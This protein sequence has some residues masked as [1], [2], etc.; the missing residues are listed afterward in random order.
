MPQTGVEYTS[1]LLVEIKALKCKP[2]A[3]Y[4]SVVRMKQTCIVARV[5]YN[6]EGGR[7]SYSSIVPGTAVVRKAR[8][9]IFTICGTSQLTLRA[10]QVLT[11]A[12]PQ[13]CTTDVLY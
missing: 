10:Q 2:S 7:V 1:T 6:K 12:Q 11:D 5:Y 4:A 8:S 3:Q 9:M 13:H